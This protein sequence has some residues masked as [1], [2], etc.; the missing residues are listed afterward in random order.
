MSRRPF[1]ALRL[2]AIAAVGSNSRLH[3]AVLLES[4]T[5]VLA[6]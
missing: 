1:A 5:A 2:A 3:A 6:A 4:P